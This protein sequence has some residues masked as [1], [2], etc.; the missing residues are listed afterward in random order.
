[1]SD[2]SGINVELWQEGGGWRFARGG[3]K[4]LLAAER[5][6]YNLFKTILTRTVGGECK[7]LHD[8]VVPRCVHTLHIE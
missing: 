4:W 1:M 8:D 3:C 5:V 2:S 6:T 7:V